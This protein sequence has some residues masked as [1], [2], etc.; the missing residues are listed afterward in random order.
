MH[1]ALAVGLGY[2]FDAYAVN[3]YGLLLPTIAASLNFGSNTAGVIGSLFLVGY[4][5]GTIG[6]G[7]AADHYGRKD[8]LGLSILM[9]GITCALGGIGSNIIWFTLMRVLTGVGG[10]GELAVG[11]PY[12]C[13]MFRSKYRAIGVGGIVFSLYSCGYILA[14]LTALFVVPHF[15]W[16]WPFYLAIVPAILLFAFRSKISESVRYVVDKAEDKVSAAQQM[17]SSE[18]NMSTSEQIAAAEALE[19]SGDHHQSVEFQLAALLAGTE[20]D[21]AQKNNPL[22]KPFVWLLGIASSAALFWGLLDTSLSSIVSASIV[23]AS[24]VFLLIVMAMLSW[25]SANSS[26]GHFWRVPIVR[27]RIGVGWLIYSANAMGYWGVT[28]FLTTFMVTKFDVSPEDAIMY[29]VM[30]YVFQFFFAYLGTGL[31]DWLGRRPIAILGALIMI[32]TTILAAQATDLNTFLIFGAIEIAMLG[33]L[34]GIGDCY[35]SEL[36]PTS[37]RGACFGVSVGGGRV[38]S[39]AAPFLV[40]AGIVAFDGPT[41]PFLATAGL[42]VLTIIGYWIGPETSQKPLEQLDEEFLAE[43]KQA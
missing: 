24:C 2:G 39:I 4:T 11:A 27:K 19:G 14:G 29:A 8:T 5:V 17:L 28:T 25:A 13:E 40:G 36:F 41:I 43:A 34:W 20:E 1:V 31:S 33:W 30:F 18:R 35:I 12:T 26:K 9:Y 3:I 22:Y 32:V 15:G 16:R 42:W 23:T 38:M 7:I 10:A 6:F 37:I 21:H